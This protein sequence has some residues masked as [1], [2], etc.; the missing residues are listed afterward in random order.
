MTQS[1]MSYA[2]AYYQDTGQFIPAHRLESG[3][4]PPASVPAAY[5]PPAG[6]SL[7]RHYSLDG[8]DELR[9]PEPSSVQNLPNHLSDPLAGLYHH[10]FPISPQPLRPHSAQRSIVPASFAASSRL[11]NDSILDGSPN[12]NGPA[13]NE[14][15]TRGSLTRHSSFMSTEVHSPHGVPHVQKQAFQRNEDRS[16]NDGEDG[17]LMLVSWPLLLLDIVPN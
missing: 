12:S 1:E 7:P 4:T 17:L 16:A 15:R 11:E 9:P 8:R 13:G 10:R 6:Q 3:G 14:S 2:P 5:P